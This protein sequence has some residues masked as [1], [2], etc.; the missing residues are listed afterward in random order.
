[1][2]PNHDFEVKSSNKT[3]EMASVIKPA[4]LTTPPCGENSADSEPYGRR[5]IASSRQNR[6]TSL[7]AKTF[8]VPAK[9]WKLA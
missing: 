6:N 1:M 5:T 2:V 3:G 9:T 8:P 4:C 7:I